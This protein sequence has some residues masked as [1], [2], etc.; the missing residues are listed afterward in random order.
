M[1]IENVIAALNNPARRRILEWL[2]DRSNFPPSLPEHADLDGVCV[3]YIQEKAGLS[4]ST[5]S[6]YMGVLKQAGLVLAERHGQWTFYRRNEGNIQV[7][8]DEVAKEL[9]KP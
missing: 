2:K 3:A 1:D 5:I 8:L 6:N 4:Q 7:F 9:L